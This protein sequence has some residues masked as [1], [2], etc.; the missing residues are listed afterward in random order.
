MPY[1][2]YNTKV[3]K[4]QGGDKLVVDAGDEIDMQPGG[5]ITADGTQAAA[6]ADVPTDVSA[7]A[8]ANAAAINSILAALR[9]IG[10]IASS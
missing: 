4:P 9:A 10:V 3:F 6:I 8:A 1:T 7:D 5:A 2:D